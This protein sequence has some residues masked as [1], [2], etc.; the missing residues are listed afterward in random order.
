M[1]YAVSTPGFEFLRLSRFISE[2]DL[3]YTLL[4]AG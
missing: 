2:V 3:W 1:T 4:I